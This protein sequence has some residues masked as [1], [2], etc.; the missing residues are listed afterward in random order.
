MRQH[1]THAACVDPVVGITGGAR[2][3]ADLAQP[4]S[5]RIGRRVW[6]GELLTVGWR[7]LLIALDDGDWRA[8]GEP[9]DVHT[10]TLSL[11]HTHTH[12]LSFSLS[13]THTQL[14]LTHTHSHRLS[15]RRRTC[16]RTCRSS[17]TTASTPSPMS[18][19][20]FPHAPGP[21]DPSVNTRPPSRA[22]LQ[23]KFQCPHMV[24]AART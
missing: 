2:V 20:P 3:H 22:L 4:G 11:T 17:S 24:G 8:G 1:H 12:T 14:S 6:S 23:D 13:L 5:H 18:V 16:G 15:H 21:S 7:R 19:P 10:H 9:T